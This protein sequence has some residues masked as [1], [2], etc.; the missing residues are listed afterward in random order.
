MTTVEAPST[1]VI[2]T[3]MLR[4]EDPALLTGEAKYTDDLAIPGALSMAVVRSPYAHARIT[5]VDG[6]GA[7]GMPGVVAVYSGADLRDAWAGADAVRVAR[8]R[9][10]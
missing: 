10:T 5:R 9:P 6:S 1:G 8:H 2:G 4:K 7:L 3:R